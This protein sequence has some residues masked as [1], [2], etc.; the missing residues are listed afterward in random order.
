MKETNKKEQLE[1]HRYCH[2]SFGDVESERFSS[3]RYEYDHDQPGVA[4]ARRLS[5]MSSA[6]V[7][8]YQRCLFRGCVDRKT[9]S[10]R[11]GI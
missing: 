7:K 8:A 6:V 5:R 1:A 3:R 11:T 9:C 4:E 10:T 2:K